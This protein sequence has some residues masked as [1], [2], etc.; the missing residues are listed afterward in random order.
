MSDYKHRILQVSRKITKAVYV[1]VIYGRRE[2]K[3][4]Y[5][6]KKSVYKR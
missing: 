2:E 6:L 5:V 1:F 4:V 3:A